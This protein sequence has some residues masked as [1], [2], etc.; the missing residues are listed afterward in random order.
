MQRSIRSKISM[1]NLQMWKSR[2]KVLGWPQRFYLIYWF[3]VYKIIKEY[4]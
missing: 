2:I 4:I 1:I 3:Y